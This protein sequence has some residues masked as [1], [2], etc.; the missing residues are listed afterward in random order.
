[1]PI[2]VAL[3]LK[4]QGAHLFG[5]DPEVGNEAVTEVKEILTHWVSWP[6]R[7]KFDAYLILT[8]RESFKSLKWAETKNASVIFDA[9]GTLSGE[10]AAKLGY[11]YQALWQPAVKPC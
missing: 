9:C 1:M 4:N 10:M 8:A 7:E 3:E 5:F 11:V 2:E 6:A